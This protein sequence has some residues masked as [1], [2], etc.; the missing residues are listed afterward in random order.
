MKNVFFVI[1]TSLMI[2]GLSFAAPGDNLKEKAGEAIYNRCLETIKDKPI[3]YLKADQIC[4]KTIENYMLSSAV[5]EIQDASEDNFKEGSSSI[6]FDISLEN[7]IQEFGDG[8][9]Y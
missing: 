7:A 3:S 4:Q 2:V 1:L 6:V 5:D 8:R 9:E